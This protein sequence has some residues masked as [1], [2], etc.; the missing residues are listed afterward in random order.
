MRTR[1]RV[2]TTTNDGLGTQRRD[3][4]A[5]CEKPPRKRTLKPPGYKQR[6]AALKRKR[7]A[8][9]DAPPRPKPPPVLSASQQQ[10][11]AKYEAPSL[12]HSTRVKVAEAKEERRKRDT[13]GD[14]SCVGGVSVVYTLVVKMPCHPSPTHLI[15]QT[16]PKRRTPKRVALKVLTQEELLAEAAATEIENTRSLQILEA[17][18]EETKRLA[19]VHRVRMEGPRVRYLSRALDGQLVVRCG[20]AVDALSMRVH[21]DV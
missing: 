21:R 5:P 15:Q 19:T 16:T 6:A 10:L 17:V 11:D 3:T 4:P 14:W 7:A 20:C 9:D 8:Q 18:E 2:G 13:V 12:R 1:S